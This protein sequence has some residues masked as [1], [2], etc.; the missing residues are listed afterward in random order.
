MRGLGAQPTIKGPVHGRKDLTA[1]DEWL[2]ELER[3]VVGAWVQTSTTGTV[4]H[5]R[6]CRGWSAVVGAGALQVG[7]G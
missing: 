1:G 2:N 7:T 6:V 4:R 5:F 3:A